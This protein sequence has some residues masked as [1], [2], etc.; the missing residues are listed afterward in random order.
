MPG[1]IKDTTGEYK[2]ACLRRGA[3]ALSLCLWISVPAAADDDDDEPAPVAQVV[4]A[5]GRTLQVPVEVQRQAG[6]RVARLETA[7]MLPERETQAQVVDVGPLLASRWQYRD[8]LAQLESARAALARSQAAL[9]RL[10]ALRRNPDDVST[11]QLLDAQTARDENAA[12]VRSADARRRSVRES[13]LRE[14]GENVERRALGG[15]DEESEL[16]AGQ[17]LL[18]IAGGGSTGRAGAELSARAATSDGSGTAVPVTLLGSAPM[19]AAGLPGE[20]WLGLVPAPGFRV[21]THVPVWLSTETAPRDGVRIPHGAV[22]WH[23]GAAWLYRRVDA[24]HFARQ[25]ISGAVDPDGS[26]FVPVA[27]L[28][29]S[30]VVVVGAQTLL[31]EELR[32]QIPDEDDDP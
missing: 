27:E 1:K 32:A 18:L 16:F 4:T 5:A 20:A 9:D 3:I 7:R 10:Q 29:G 12:Q 2:P 15:T 24:T 22:V 11:R 25:M 30:D 31:S 14:W 21:G 13:V 23:G 17:A 8:A 19:G 26:W 28:A 6:I